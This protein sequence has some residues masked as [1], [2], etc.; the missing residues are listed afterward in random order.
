MDCLPSGIT[1]SP[2][3]NKSKYDNKVRFSFPENEEERESERNNDSHKYKEVEWY[4]L[5]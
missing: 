4:K 1:P 2:T 5:V 3:N